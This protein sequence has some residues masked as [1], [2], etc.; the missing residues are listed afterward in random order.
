M[1]FNRQVVLVIWIGKDLQY[2]ERFGRC[3]CL[4][5]QFLPSFLYRNNQAT[6]ENG[7]RMDEGADNEDEDDDDNEDKDEEDNDEDE[8]D[9][10][11]EDD[12]GE[13]DDDDEEGDADEEEEEE[14][15]DGISEDQKDFDAM[16]ASG[17]L[18]LP[19]APVVVQTAESLKLWGNMCQQHSEQPEEPL[20]LSSQDFP[21]MAPPCDCHHCVL[22]AQPEPRLE[23]GPFTQS[24]IPLRDREHARVELNG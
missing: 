9:E 14:D 8:D 17:K 16:L 12:D 24:F 6:D 13:E 2:S 19:T 10:E 22:P 21:A 5:C 23:V 11:E 15:D 1:L 3:F 4:S 20:E 7:I 18:G